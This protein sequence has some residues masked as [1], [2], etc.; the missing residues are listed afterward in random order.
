MGMAVCGYG[1]SSESLPL[2]WLCSIFVFFA[3]SFEVALNGRRSFTAAVRVH[4]PEFTQQK[5]VKGCDCVPS[6]HCVLFLSHFIVLSGDMTERI[7][8]SW[9]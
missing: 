7:S 5:R 3:S 8:Q 6:L 1:S 4:A 2:C 9:V